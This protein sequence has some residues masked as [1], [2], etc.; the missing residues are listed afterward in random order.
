MVDRLIQAT[1]NWDQ[2]EK[3]LGPTLISVYI[4]D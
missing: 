1:A 2:Q 3:A 4:A